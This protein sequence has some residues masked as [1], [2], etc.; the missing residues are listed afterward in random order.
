MTKR[1]RSSRP[2]RPSRER[3]PD[4]L[5]DR[6]LLD[7]SSPGSG[8]G[9]RGV[10]DRSSPDRGPLDRGS[11]DRGVPGRGLPDRGARPD[12][13]P[14]RSQPVVRVLAALTSAPESSELTGEARALAEFRGFAVSGAFAESGA[15]GAAPARGAD[16]RPPTR[17][18]TRAG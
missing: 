1:E 2:D 12:G 7:Q 13:D 4:A 14:A 17:A 5:L 15:L 16:L 6:Y 11:P 18:G 8:S 10:P 9:D 3:F